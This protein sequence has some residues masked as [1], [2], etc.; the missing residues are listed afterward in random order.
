MASGSTPNDA[1]EPIP[2]NQFPPSPHL[3]FGVE[4]APAHLNYA[5][6]RGHMFAVMRLHDPPPHTP[7][8]L[9]WHPSPIKGPGDWVPLHRAKT[10]TWE[11]ARLL[12]PHRMPLDGR[13]H[14]VGIRIWLD[15]E[16]RL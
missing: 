7:D 1:C 6:A 9:Y 12:P 5:G 8:Y 16:K 3:E 15:P 13:W 4:D 2:P 14:A 10:W 11:A